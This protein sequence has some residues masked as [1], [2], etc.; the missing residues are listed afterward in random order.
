MLGLITDIQNGLSKRFRDRAN[1]IGITLSR[2][3]W[4]VLTTLTGRPGLTQTELADL[5]G[6][7]RAPLGKLIDKLEA[8]NWVERRPDPEDRRV[9]RLYLV[10][11]TSS[12]DEPTQSISN[13][14][15]NELLE[16]LPESDQ[17]AFRRALEHMHRK[18]GFSPTPAYMNYSYSELAN[19]DVA[20]SEHG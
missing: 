7:G 2:P 14:V 6:I 10:R 4:G 15:V 12:I 17:L 19:L 16:D 18:L 3:Q 8:Q 13:Q 9:N 20:K 5:V 11:S 1:Q